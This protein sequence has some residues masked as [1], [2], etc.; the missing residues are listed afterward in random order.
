MPGCMS[1]QIID[2]YPDPDQV[3]AADALAQQASD[4]MILM[5]EIVGPFELRA[6][7]A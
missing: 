5:H 3:D 1:S 4:F 6:A 7:I 2:V